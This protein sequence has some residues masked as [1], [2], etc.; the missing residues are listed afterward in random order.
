MGIVGVW[1][2]KK[3]LDVVSRTWITFEIPAYGRDF[4]SVSCL[5]ELSKREAMIQRSMHGS[6]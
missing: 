6:V 1:I 4:E 2:K 5:L 3:R